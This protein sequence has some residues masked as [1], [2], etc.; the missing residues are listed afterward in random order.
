MHLK[1]FK[2]RLIECV[3]RRFESS[4]ADDLENIISS[5]PLFFVLQRIAHL[6]TP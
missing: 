2:S 5:P 4:L 1:P 6:D 3:E